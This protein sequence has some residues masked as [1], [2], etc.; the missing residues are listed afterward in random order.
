MKK[1]ILLL[2]I[3]FLSVTLGCYGTGQLDCYNDVK[4]R[5]D[6]VQMIPGERYKFIAEKEGKYFY[7]ETM[8]LGRGKTISLEVM[9]EMEIK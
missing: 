9:I 4:D 8:D 1:I 3:I 2:V 5:Y 6:S 7:I